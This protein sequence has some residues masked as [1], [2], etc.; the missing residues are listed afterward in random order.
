[1]TGLWV[2]DSSI[3]PTNLGVNPQHTIAAVAWLVALLLTAGT[4]PNS[5]TC[6]CDYVWG[7]WWYPALD[8]LVLGLNLVGWLAGATAGWLVRRGWSGRTLHP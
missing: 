1:M 5:A 2:A 4:D 7:R 3:F 6:D 8:L